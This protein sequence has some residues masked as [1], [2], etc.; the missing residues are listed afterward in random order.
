MFHQLCIQY[1]LVLRLISIYLYAG[2]VIGSGCG[3]YESSWHKWSVSD[4]PKPPECWPAPGR[5]L[6]TKLSL[7]LAALLGRDPAADPGWYAALPKGGSEAMITTCCLNKRDKIHSSQSQSHAPYTA[8]HV[9]PI[10][11]LLC[12][13]LQWAVTATKFCPPTTI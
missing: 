5:G 4:L 10:T 6:C 7:L 12:C 3:N 8:V 2:R 11:Q 13:S 1:H 9:L